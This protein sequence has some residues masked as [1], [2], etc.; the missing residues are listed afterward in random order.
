MMLL[1][2]A[3][4]DTN[5]GVEVAFAYLNRKYYRKIG[6]SIIGQE[7]DKFLVM[8]GYRHWFFQNFSGALL[9]H[10]AYSMGEPNLIFRN[11]AAAFD[12]AAAKPAYNGLDLSFQYDYEFQ[13]TKFWVLDVR[14]SYSFDFEDDETP[15]AVA[16]LLAYK[17]VLDVD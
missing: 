10:S 1:A 12:T 6:A 3:D 7:A 2:N 17:Q 16:L 5:G 8:V 9:I 4:V 13:E 14:Y 15:S 11:S